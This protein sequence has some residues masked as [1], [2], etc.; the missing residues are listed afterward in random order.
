[1]KLQ[2]HLIIARLA[3]E[4]SGLTPIKRAAFCIGSLI[5]DLSPMQFIHRHFYR[6]SGGYIIRKLEKLSGKSSFF[7]MLELGKAA[8][9]VSDFCCSVHFNGEIGNVRRHILYERRLNRYA[10]EKYALLKSECSSL[11]ALQSVKDVLSEYFRNEKF[12]F[13]TDII[14][15]VKAC[16]AV[17]ETAKS[18]NNVF[19]YSISDECVI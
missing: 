11:K 5:P 9:Y 8:H 6:Q 15:A 14:Y 2:T 10:V 4:K 12:S 19:I 7:S 13:H 1:M 17:C 3:A 18:G 16:A